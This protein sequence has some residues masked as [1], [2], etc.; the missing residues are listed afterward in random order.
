MNLMEHLKTRK[1]NIKLRLGARDMPPLAK[2]DES[3]RARYFVNKFQGPRTG[4]MYLECFA[5]MNGSF[6]GRYSRVKSHVE[7]FFLVSDDR[8]LIFVYPTTLFCTKKK[9]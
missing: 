2:T 8:K 7:P 9:A 4:L 1:T 3:L 6:D 5:L